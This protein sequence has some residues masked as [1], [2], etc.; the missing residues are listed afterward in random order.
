MCL[1]ICDSIYIH[2]TCTCSK[3]CLVDRLSSKA[4]VVVVGTYVSKLSFFSLALLLIVVICTK[5]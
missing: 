3:G 5:S 4:G 2:V 1:Y